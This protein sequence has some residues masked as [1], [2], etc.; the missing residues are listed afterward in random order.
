[1]RIRIINSLILQEYN[2]CFTTVDRS[3]DGLAILPLSK[4]MG[5]LPEV[6]SGYML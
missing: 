2:I 4:T 5:I 3:P 6:W 1:M